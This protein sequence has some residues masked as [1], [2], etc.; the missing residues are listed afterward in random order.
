MRITM[1]Y[2]TVE[3]DGIH[4]AI[5]NGSRILLLKRINIPFIVN[6]GAWSFVAGSRK[7]GEGYAAA[8][9]REIR[10]ETGLDAD[11][12]RLLKGGYSVFIAD[13]SRRI[14]WKNRFFVFST[15]RKEIR[16]N[17]ENS[18]YRWASYREMVSD[19]RLMGM[20]YSRER[21][22]GAIRGCNVNSAVKT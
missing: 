8:A 4:A 14:K 5:L 3:N 12:V 7:R 18:M 20:L 22:L 19:Q 2:K 9:L 10:E 1:E 15:S 17:F 11:D 6:P 21:I 13:P 16:L